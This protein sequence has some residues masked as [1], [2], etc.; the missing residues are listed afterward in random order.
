MLI[1]VRVNKLFLAFQLLALSFPSGSVVFGL[2][3][4]SPQGGDGDGARQSELDCWLP[5]VLHLNLSLYVSN[6]MIKGKFLTSLSITVFLCEAVGFLPPPSCP[7]IV[8]RT[9][10]DDL[11]KVP[12]SS[13]QERVIISASLVQGETL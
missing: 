9:K 10:E 6:Y 5:I 12:D 7:A 1:F 3:R 13:A 11:C 2:A 4:A 8:L